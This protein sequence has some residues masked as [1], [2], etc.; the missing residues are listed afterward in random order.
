ML[1]LII[2][3]LALFCGTLSFSQNIS[4]KVAISDKVDNTLLTKSTSVLLI[5]QNNNSYQLISGEAVGLPKSSK[6]N[7]L[8]VDNSNEVVFIEFVDKNGNSHEM[9]ID[10]IKKISS[11]IEWDNIVLYNSK[12]EKIGEQKFNLIFE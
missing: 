10:S 6:N 11:D 12:K 4:Y 5:N 3:S 8:I 9:S 7:I 1:R 2:I